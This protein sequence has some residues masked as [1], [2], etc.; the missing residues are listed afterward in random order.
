MKVTKDIFLKLMFSIPKNY[1]TSTITWLSQFTHIVFDDIV[2]LI[3][4]VIKNVIVTKLFIRGR[5]LIIYLAF[6]TES[7]FDV[8][9]KY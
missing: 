6:V 8:P 1:M 4:F 9:K 3:Y 2:L 5:K 7:Y